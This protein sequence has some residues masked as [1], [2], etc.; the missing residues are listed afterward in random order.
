MKKNT[1]ILLIV[2]VAA[3]L[4]VGLMLL[5]IFMPKGDDQATSTIDEGIDMVVTVDENGVHQ[6][7][8]KTNAKGEIANNSYG[9]LVEY[10]TN[11]VASIHLE[12]EKGTLDITS[13]TPKDADGNTQATKYTIKGYED[14]D[15]QGGMADTIASSAANL[16]FIK[17]VTLKKEDAADFGCDKPRATANVTYADGTKSVIMLGNDAP[18]GA[19]TYVKFGDSDTIYLVETSKVSA[20]DYGL[21]DLM[22]KSINQPVSNSDNAKP[23]SITLSGSN[24][25]KSIELVPNTNNKVNASYVMTA[26]VERYANEKESSLVEGAIRGITSDGVKLV[27]PSSEQLSNAGLS[28]P[29]AEIKAVYPDT[30]VNLIASKPDGDGNVNVMEKGGKLVYTISADKLPWITTSYEALANE[31]VLYPRMVALS[32]MSVDDGSKTYD[33]KLSSKEVES[34]DEDG[35]TTTSSTTT[36]QYG[37]KEIEIGDFSGFFQ[38]VALLELAD[39]SDDSVSGSPIL[40]VTYTYSE[41]G[42][43]DKVEFYSAGDGYCMATLNG[44]TLGKVNKGSVN[45]I[46]TDVEALVS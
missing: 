40:T 14:Y 16:E 33:F 8:I 13:E 30:T 35:N 12:N 28:S 43:T 15:M 19:G 22:N 17:V 20:F 23:S 1:K 18:Q 7:E 25:S 26:P 38:K 29:Y 21:T 37:D 32:N 9:T 42:S 44:K 24:F 36:V 46:V 45:S 27:D 3:V 39:A 4:L 34:T 6:A 41:D 11:E 10:D 2:S 5:L 31:Y